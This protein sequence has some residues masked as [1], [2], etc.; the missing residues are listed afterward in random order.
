MN[1]LQLLSI[2]AAAL[3]QAAAASPAPD[4]VLRVTPERE[5]IYKSGPREV[6]VQVEVEGRKVEDD[7][8]R[9]PMNLA[10]VL[11]RSGSME[12]AK[13]E[14]ARQAAAMALDKLS[15]RR[16][17]LARHLRQRDEPAHR[18][19]ARRQSRQPRRAEAAHPPH[20]A[21]R[22]HRVARRRRARREAGAAEV[23]Q[24]A[25]QS[26]HPP[27]RRH[28]QRRPEPHVRSLEPRPRAAQRW[29]LGQHRRPRR[30]LQRRPDDGARRGEQRQLLLRERRREIAGHLRPGAR[31]IA[32]AARPQHRH[33]H[34]RAGRRA[35][36]GDRRP[37]GHQ[38]RR[39]RRGDRDA[40][41]VRRGEAPLPR[42]LLL[43]KR[44][45]RTRSKPR[46]SS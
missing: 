32:F 39:P 13:I 43:Q 10:I 12:G 7:G 41:A 4:V 15:G 29:H 18:A 9:S 46:R 40:R 28:R 31:C 34:Q 14:K 1:K 30:R 35:P 11:D 22:Q 27:L 42:A 37:S 24:G 5:Y 8:R 25:R 23:C 3:A 17:L 44:R 38:V 26:R 2:S 33:P 16:H 20:P 36:E 21:G 19:A 45:C 6:I